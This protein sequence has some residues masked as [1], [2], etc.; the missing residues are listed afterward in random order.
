M[1]EAFTALWGGLDLALSDMETL[2]VYMGRHYK[3][4]FACIFLFAKLYPTILILLFFLP[5]QNAG[6][7]LANFLTTFILH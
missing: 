6:L 2:I 1:A 5:L 4:S 3:R 7:E